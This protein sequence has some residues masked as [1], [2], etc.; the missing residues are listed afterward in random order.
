MA[1][2][3]FEEALS[4]ALERQPKDISYP[5]YKATE[6]FSLWLSGYV[7]K[8]RD[9]HGFKVT[10]DDKVR[11]E[12][13]RS[14]SGKLSVGSALDAYNR[15]EDPDKTNYERL[16]AKLTE[17]FVDPAEKRRFNEDM[18]YNKRQKSQSLKKFMQE[19]KKDMNR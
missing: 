17:E 16:V 14:I 19:I 1:N 6:D 7:A 13:V 12:V 2:P 9:A 10:E 5:D 3:D 15:L 4:K 18:S 11:A 8:I